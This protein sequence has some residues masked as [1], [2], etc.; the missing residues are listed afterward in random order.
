M[1]SL[2][3]LRWKGLKSGCGQ[4]HGGGE[5]RE[6]CLVLYRVERV[7]LKVW[8]LVVEVARDDAQALIRGCGGTRGFS[9]HAGCAGHPH[10]PIALVL[11]AGRDP[12]V[13]NR[14]RHRSSSLRK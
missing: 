11:I 2:P 9:Q 6:F 13:D 3:L 12:F 8:M 5:A 4:L 7:E 14:H 10:H 1:I